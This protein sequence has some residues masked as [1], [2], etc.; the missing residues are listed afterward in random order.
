MINARSALKTLL[1][2]VKWTDKNGEAQS[3]NVYLESDLDAN[4]RARY[5]TPALLI[6]G[7]STFPQPLNVGWDEWADTTE[8]VV[9]LYLKHR[10]G[11]YDVESTLDNITNQIETLARQNKDG[12]GGAD[13]LKLISVDDRGILE[14]N[15]TV[16]RDFTFE[17][18]STSWW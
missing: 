2:T 8:V 10:A 18:Y 14:E 4:R 7:A 1:S 9:S 16:R 5:K 12:I 6:R 13:Y 11:D 17:F 15:G 3:V